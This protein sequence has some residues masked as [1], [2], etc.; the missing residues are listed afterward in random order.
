MLL[1]IMADKLTKQELRDRGMSEGFA[2]ILDGKLTKEEAE[3]HI[4]I[5]RQVRAQRQQDRIE[6]RL[7]RE[8][9]N[10]L[11]RALWQTRLYQCSVL[12]GRCGMS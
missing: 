5:E 4:N 7:R 1:Q 10:A 6:S 9:P 12:T 3:A 8:L 11:A 2:G